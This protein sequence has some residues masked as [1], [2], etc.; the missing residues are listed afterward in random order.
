MQRESRK[1]PVFS[2]LGRKLDKAFTRAG[3]KMEAAGERLQQSL[4]DECWSD[5]ADRMIAYLNDEV[6]PAVRA[7]SGRA[8]KKA[9]RKLS[10]FADC[11]DERRA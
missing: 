2:R 10:Q 5:E 3:R 4:K 1:K 11:L 6:V 9:A 8:L 7:G